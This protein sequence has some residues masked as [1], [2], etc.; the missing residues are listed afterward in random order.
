MPVAISAADNPLIK[1]LARLGEASERRNQG[2]F[3]AEGLRLIDA[4]IQAGWQPVHLLVRDDETL[5]PG[6]PAAITVSARVAQRLSRAT[7]A[8]GY[9]AA[10]ALPSVP[11]LNPA[12]GGLVLV[13]V[14]DPGN[15]GTLIRSAA[16]FGRRQIIVDGG[17]DP[18][19]PKAVQA[20]AGALALVHLFN[21]DASLLPSD[22]RACA[23]VVSGGQPPSAFS[24]GPR[25]LVIGG[26]ANGIPPA[27]L[28][29]CA[30]RL[31]LPMPGGTESLN[32]AVAGSIAAYVLGS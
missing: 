1:Q 31:T 5:P 7:S 15:M 14:A 30:E 24:A 17:A 8:S 25:W 12:A 20:S 29:R 28:E 26:E 27:W 3:L 6:W 18:F 4:F 23:L 32:A 19:G 21:G 2:L 10:F 22:A 9:V 11:A 16:A 13:G